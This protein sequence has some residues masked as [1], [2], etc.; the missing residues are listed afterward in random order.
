ML[1]S[2]GDSQSATEREDG[3]AE[4]DDQEEAS[5]PPPDPRSLVADLLS[6][7]IGCAFGRWDVRIARDAELVAGLADPFAPLPVCSPGMLV[8]PDGLPAGSG[9]LVSEAWLRARPDAITLPAAGAVATPTISDEQ[10]PLRIAWDG[11]LVDD[12]DNPDDVVRRVRQV[13]ELLWGERAE[14]IEQETCDLLGVRGLRDYF[15]NPRAFFADHI[16]RYSKS[17]R[18]APIYWLLQSDRRNYGLWLYYHRLDQ[19]TLFKAL[20]GYVNPKL[21]LE[22]QRLGSLRQAREA[23]PKTGAAARQFERQVDEQEALV[24]EIGRFQETLRTIANL[25]LTPDLDDGVLL[26]IAP[27]HPLVPWPEAKR[28]WQELTGGKYAWSSM[29]KRMQARGLVARAVKA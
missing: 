1:A 6:Y 12:P 21:A 17:R 3:E 4:E 26:S 9:G 7:A 11:V 10:Y 16:K 13:L 20:Q 19:D 22:E 15:R 27:L 8:G 18:K 24:Q 28:A 29:S 5:A 2:A 14:A 25:Q 23:G